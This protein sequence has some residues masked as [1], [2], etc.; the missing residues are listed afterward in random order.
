MLKKVNLVVSSKTFICW[1]NL[2]CTSEIG[3][4]IELTEGYY[5]TITRYLN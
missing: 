2:Y 1:I 5:K 4:R 3:G